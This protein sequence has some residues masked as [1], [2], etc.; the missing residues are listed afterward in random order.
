[1]GPKPPR[2]ISCDGTDCC[3]K[4]YLQGFWNVTSKNTT[5][6]DP[7]PQKKGSQD[8]ILKQKNPHIFLKTKDLFY[9]QEGC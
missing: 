9:K 1:M 6:L 8:E 3:D 5:N 2:D 7:P 4:V